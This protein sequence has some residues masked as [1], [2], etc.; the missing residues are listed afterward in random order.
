[1]STVDHAV[2]AVLEDE[3]FLIDGERSHQRQLEL[4]HRMF[5]PPPTEPRLD[6]ELLWASES[7][8]AVVSGEILDDVHPWMAASV[9]ATSGV[10]R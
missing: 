8:V 7:G 10:Q 1:M 2:V 9:L 5:T 6:R 3:G 4:A